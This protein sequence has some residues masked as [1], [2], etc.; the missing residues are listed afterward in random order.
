MRAGK[1]KPTPAGVLVVGFISGHDIPIR[2]WCRD[3]LFE[4]HEP[5]RSKAW[6]SGWQQGATCLVCG[7][8]VVPIDASWWVKRA[9]V[10]D[11]RRCMRLLKRRAKHYKNVY[12]SLRRRLANY[13]EE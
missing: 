1:V 7:D 4:T 2:M 3:H 5:I 8:D 13:E 6:Q 11:I 9:T 10:K 12:T